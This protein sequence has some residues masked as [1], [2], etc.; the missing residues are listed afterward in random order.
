MHHGKKVE[1]RKCRLRQIYVR[2]HS[3][4][5]NH[6]RISGFM[7]SV[8]MSFTHCSPERCECV[9]FSFRLEMVMVQVSRVQLENVVRVSPV[10]GG[11]GRSVVRTRSLLNKPLCVREGQVQTGESAGPAALMVSVTTLKDRL[12]QRPSG[13]A[14]CRGHGCPSSLEGACTVLALSAD[15]FLLSLSLSSWPV[16]MFGKPTRG[17]L[18]TCLS[19]LT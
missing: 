10:F 19:R 17:R 13:R 5:G 1:K 8:R 3:Q 11:I 2:V 6:I 18:L 16:P 4:K 12:T 7:S 14:W 9:G 15:S